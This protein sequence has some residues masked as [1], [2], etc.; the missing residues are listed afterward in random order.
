M[1]IVSNK[2]FVLIAFLLGVGRAMVVTAKT[3]KAPPEPDVSPM[4]QPIPPGFSI[5]E[6]IYILLIGALLLGVYMI[7]K[8]KLKIKTPM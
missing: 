7:H 3:P 6:N 8:N 4:S 2:Y 5:D 1:R